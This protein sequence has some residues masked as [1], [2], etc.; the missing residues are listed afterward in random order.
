MYSIG[1]WIARP[2][3]CS[4]GFS[5]APSNGAGKRRSNGFEVISMNSRK[6]ILTMP[7]TDSTRAMSTSG[8]CLL[9]SATAAVQTDSVSAHSSSEPSCDPQTPDMRYINGCSRLECCDTYST[10]KSCTMNA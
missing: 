10:E 7:M 1:G 2:G 3:S 4:S 8:R 6:P 5:E 9:N